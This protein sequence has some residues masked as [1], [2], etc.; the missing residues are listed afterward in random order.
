MSL[1]R[2]ML[3]AV[4]LMATSTRALADAWITAEVPAAV[5]VSSPHDKDFGAGAMPSI[6]LYAG[7]LPY[8]AVGAKV[9]GGAL[10]NGA[11]PGQGLMDPGLGGLGIAG[12]AA[13]LHGRGPWLEVFGGGGI[14]GDDPVPAFELGV[15][16]ALDA[17]AMTVGPSLRLL[18]VRGGERATDPGSAS[19]LL[20]GVELTF[21]GRPK[22]APAPPLVIA[23]DADRVVD[24]DGTCPVAGG[25]GCPRPIED[26]DHDGIKDADD[27]CLDQPETVNG[28]EDNDGCPDEGLFVV[29]NDRIVLDE[30]VLFDLNRARVKRSGKKVIEAIAEAWRQHPEW[31]RMVVEGHADV[32]GPDDFNVRLSETRAH[33]TREALIES[34]VPAERVESIGYGATR[35]RDPGTS[36]EA[37]QHNRRVEFVIIRGPGRGG[38]PAAQPAEAAAAPPNEVAGA[39]SG[40][41]K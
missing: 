12:V 7:L 16:W 1:P 29:E 14:T 34:G 26:R 4:T 33:R 9:R 5:P 36:E 18:H 6:G 41:A 24:L 2:L 13:R 31:D 21:G 37:F 10:S 38:A 39:P 35:P 15:G 28:V 19:M 20:V 25:D 32:R 17:G 8:L 40:G 30:R 27:A 22:R 23:L 11:P 3:V